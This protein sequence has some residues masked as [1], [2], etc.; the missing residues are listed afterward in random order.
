MNRLPPLTEFL[1]EQVW[2]VRDRAETLQP[3]RLP[4]PTAV[5]LAVILDE[6][7]DAALL[8]RRPTRTNR[9]GVAVMLGRM[10]RMLEAIEHEAWRDE[11][12]RQTELL[13]T[14]PSETLRTAQR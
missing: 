12:P 13:R 5:K 9:E 10:R 2:A 1:E 11:G 8:L 7:A 4:E 3:I 14:A 6:L